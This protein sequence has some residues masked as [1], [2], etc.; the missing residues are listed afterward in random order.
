M[1]TLLSV[2]L[3]AANA[4][5]IAHADTRVVGTV[6]FT[7]DGEHQTWYIL[8][9]GGDMLPNALWLAMGPERGALSIA[10]Y[11]DPETQ[12]VADE[13]TGSPLPSEDAAALVISIAFPID[14]REQTYTL[15]TE[16]GGGPAVVMLLDSWSSPL[17]HFALQEGPGEIRLTKID[18]RPGES[19]SFSGT[20][21][22]TMQRATG[23]SRTIEEG[24][25]EIPAAPFFDRPS[26]GP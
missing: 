20:F 23:E 3:L 18:A 2:L 7:L 6:E 9:P 16:R 13:A 19:A 12:F 22:G 4:A 24:S 1:K 5:L 21:R 14:A 25:F 8:D 11:Q 17:E 26:P 10:A 15:P